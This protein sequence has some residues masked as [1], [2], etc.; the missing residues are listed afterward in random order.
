[1]RTSAPVASSRCRKTKSRT[2]IVPARSSC[3]I[4]SAMRPSKRAPSRKPTARIWTGPTISGMSFSSLAGMLRASHR[5][6]P[7]LK[8]VHQRA[9]APCPWCTHPRSGGRACWPR[10]GCGRMLLCAMT[11]D[12]SAEP[13]RVF[14]VDDQPP[15][16]EAARRVVDA[17]AGFAWAGE[18]DSGA[19]AVRRVRECTPDLVIMDVRMP[20]MD[21]I[22][23]ARMVVAEHPG[24]AVLLVSADPLTCP[25]TDLLRSRALAFSRKRDFG[26]AVLR[27]L[28]F[29]QSDSWASGTQ[30]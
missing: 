29:R 30:P 1:M 8:G 17:T 16:R 12:P 2:R 3:S 26:P 14:A 6:D 21:G 15:F 5:R 28:R 13:M 7:G 20:G 18:A 11:P 22:E 9:H 23:A 10:R 19:E 4:W 27:L 24:V 25:T